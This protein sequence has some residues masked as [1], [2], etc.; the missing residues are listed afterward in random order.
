MMRKALIS[1]ADSQGHRQAGVT[2]ILVALALMAIIAMAAISI[3]VITLYLA[4]EEAQRTADQAALAAAR[5]LS[6]SGMT[7]DYSNTTGNWGAICGP[8]GIATKAAKALVAQNTISRLV[9]GTA[10]VTYSAGLRGSISSSTD[11]S[12]LGTTAFGVNPLVTVQFTVSGLPTFFSRIWGKSG[13]SVSASAS[14]EA[15]NPS[16]SGST[17]NQTVGAITPVQPRCVKPWVVANQDPWWPT[18]VG[19]IYCNQPGGPGACSKIVQTNGA[20]AGQIIHAGITADGTGSGSSGVIGETFWLSSD[21]RNNQ[22]GC[23]LRLK[24]AVPTQP[25]ANFTNASGNLQGP[26]NLLYV[27]SQIGTP[28]T[29]VPSCSMDSDYEWAIGGCDQA[30]NYACGVQNANTVDLSINPDTDTSNGVQCLIHQNTSGDISN[31]TG[32]DYFNAGYILPP[33]A[34]YPF[35]ILAGTANPMVTAGLPSG[36]PITNSTSIVSLPIYDDTAVTL[37]PGVTN[38]VTFVGFLQVF[39]NAVDQKGNVNVTVLNVAGCG[40]GTDE[41]LG[42]PVLGTSPVP[43]RLITPP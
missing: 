38:P 10:N 16:F 42:P 8:D 11:C 15:F 28:V 5:I 27:P 23:N 32:Q 3:D 43:T 19:G 18:P 14:A 20:T 21:C 13:N 9:P 31:P 40:N 33:P 12:T 2:M 30:T 24:A 1:K 25:E 37:T 41:T 36:T 34:G 22:S 39:I 29:G 17:R 26:P 4:K 35:Q 7:G 6:I